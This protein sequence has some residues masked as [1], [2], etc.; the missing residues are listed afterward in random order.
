MNSF[1]QHSQSKVYSPC[2]VAIAG[3]SLKQGVLNDNIYHAMIKPG[4][5]PLGYAGIA[6][7]HSNETHQIELPRIGDEVED[8]QEEIFEEIFEFLSSR[9]RVG[10]EKLPVLYAAENNLSMVTSV[11]ET[12]CE[13]FQRNKELFQIY[14]LQCMFRILRNTVAGS[15]CWQ[16]D[17]M[18][19]QEIEKDVYNYTEEIACEFHQMADVLVF[20]SRS[21]VV[22]YAYIIC[23]NCCR[24]ANIDL[25]PGCH[26]P[27]N[28]KV[29]GYQNFNY[30]SRKTSKRSSTRY[31]SDTSV[32]EDTSDVETVISI[33]RSTVWDEA[34]SSSSICF[35]E[36]SKGAVSRNNS[37]S[38]AAYSECVSPKDV[39]SN[40]SGSGSYAGATSLKTG[41]SGFSKRPAALP[42][43]VTE[44]LG[45]MTLSQESMDNHFPAIGSGRGRNFSNF[46]RGKGRGHPFMKSA[47]KS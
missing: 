39:M 13:R 30:K 32:R 47:S 42:F 27:S 35:P 19:Y 20:C 28:A 21:I 16:S 25:I 37:Q 24:D 44:G 1:C 18:S 17:T 4:P 6:N 36:L 2:E 41:N 29:S 43:N 9:R 8:N 26:V 45:G 23:D 38:V 15:D 46:V 10:S 22:R 14:N 3:F 33:G 11:F 31:T 40:A 5:L 12:W 7:Q 34:S